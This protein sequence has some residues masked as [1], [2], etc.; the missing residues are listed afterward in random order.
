M[1]RERDPEQ[2][3]SEAVAQLTRAVASFLEVREGHPSVAAELARRKGK[4]ATLAKLDVEG[5]SCALVLVPAMDGRIT[6]REKEVGQLVGHA[7]G[8]KGIA[9]RLG[10]SPQTVKS[11]FG[12]IFQ[13]TGFGSRAE[14]ARYAG[15]ALEDPI[16]PKRASPIG[17][18][19]S[20]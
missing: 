20:S 12:R 17:L 18:P 2:T 16:I 3:L 1:T 8:D 11:H 13:K 9:R 7:Y 19:L 6:P 15:V 4:Q 10:I 14:L 5:Q